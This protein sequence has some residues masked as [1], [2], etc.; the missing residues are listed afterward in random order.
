MNIQVR[1]GDVVH[2]I[3]GRRV[4]AV[5]EGEHFVHLTC[6]CGAAT[7]VAAQHEVIWYALHLAAPGVAPGDL[8]AIYQNAVQAVAVARIE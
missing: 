7:E 8:S 6:V 5:V 2:A 3:T 1:E 4:D